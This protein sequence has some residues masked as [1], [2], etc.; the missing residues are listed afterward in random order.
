MFD[1]FESL[2]ARHTFPIEPGTPEFTD[3][4]ITAMLGAEGVFALVAEGLD[5]NPP[6]A[7]GR[8]R[9]LNVRNVTAPIR[10]RAVKCDLRGSRRTAMDR[11]CRAYPASTGNDGEA[12]ALSTSAE[13][14]EA[15]HAQLLAWTVINMRSH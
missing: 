10:E 2:A 5:K 14:G 12:L 8:W 15:E 11:D 3:F 1:A 13:I 9:V 6:A 4:Q 7:A